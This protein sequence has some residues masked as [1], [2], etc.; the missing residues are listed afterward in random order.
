VNNRKQQQQQLLLL[1]LLCRCENLLLCILC[2]FSMLWKGWID[3]KRTTTVLLDF[4][5]GTPI[6]VKTKQDETPTTTRTAV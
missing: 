3:A 4:T 6:P 5:D 2:G 1:L